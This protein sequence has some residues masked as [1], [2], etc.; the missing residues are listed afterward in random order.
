MCS[1]TRR[2]GA[3]PRGRGRKVAGWASEERRKA[4]AKGDA[5]GAAAPPNADAGAS[6]IQR[7]KRA[8]GGGAVVAPSFTPHLTPRLTPRLIPRL[9]PRSTPRGAPLE[10]RCATSVVGV[11][12][13][14]APLGRASGRPG[15]G[16]VRKSRGGL[17][18]G[19]AVVLRARPRAAR[20]D[21]VVRNK[22]P[23]I[24]LI[25][26]LRRRFGPIR[27]SKTREL[28]ASWTKF[29]T[30]ALILQRNGRWWSKF[31]VRNSPGSVMS[32]LFVPSCEK[33]RLERDRS[34]MVSHRPEGGDPRSYPSGL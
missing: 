23:Q 14:L 29:P 27:G 21:D 2:D 18:N 30:M 32:R 22:L 28:R 1:A 20:R 16:K 24:S 11:F 9:T 6:A 31:E 10:L 5:A 17:D 26:A 25:A 34:Q 7:K 8:R 12:Y 33:P 19:R 3:K 13:F 15:K 4:Q